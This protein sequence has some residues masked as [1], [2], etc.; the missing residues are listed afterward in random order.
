MWTKLL[1]LAALGLSACATPRPA[2][3]LDSGDPR[4]AAF[5]SQWNENARARNALRGRAH[6]AVDGDVRL[7]GNQIVVLERPAR[8]RIEVLGLLNQ[9]A[10]VIATDG[11]RFEILR[12]ADRSYDTGEVRP[13]L[14]WREAHLALTPHEAV[15]L[16]LG[17]PTLDVE[18]A[19]ARAMGNVGD[20][21]EWVRMDLVDADRRVRRR[22]AFGAASELREFEVLDDRCD[23]VW[24]AQF[25]DYAP[26]GEVPFAH[27]IVLDVSVGAAHVEIELRDVELNPEL[28][29]GIFRIRPRA[30]TVGQEGNAG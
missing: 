6:L 28:A 13:D 2:I 25:G 9:T 14:L 24:R 15:E 21:G 11:E 5:L 1:A 23:V 4:P 29:P 22:I 17:G 19:P 12:T 30:E 16:M 26:V 7:R 18:F 27:S 10:A 8:M 3:P 20:D